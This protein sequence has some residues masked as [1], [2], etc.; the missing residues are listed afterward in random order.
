MSSPSKL[1]NLEGVD[2]TASALDRRMSTDLP[3]ISGLRS[4]GS[5]SSTVSMIELFESKGLSMATPNSTL[6][7]FSFSPR[8]APF[9][10]RFGV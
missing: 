3:L 1:L 6:F 8:P 7:D 10:R 5:G 4:I 9:L 2:S